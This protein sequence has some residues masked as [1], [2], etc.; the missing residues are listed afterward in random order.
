MP[1]MC[2]LSS[3][4][5]WLSKL[6]SS[7]PRRSTGATRLSYVGCGLLLA[8]ALAACAT[9]T[10]PAQV[11]PS[12]LQEAPPA[13]DFRTRLENFFAEKQTELTN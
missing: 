10:P 3:R 13:G 12:V 8:N 5:A 4:S 2:G 9:A 6:G 11:T 1:S 7:V